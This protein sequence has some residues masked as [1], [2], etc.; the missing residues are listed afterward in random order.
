MRTLL[1]KYFHD[2][3][4]NHHRDMRDY[5]HSG[6]ELLN[7]IDLDEHILDVGCGNNLFRSHY[8]NLIGIDIANEHADHVVSIELYK[9]DHRFDVALCL[10]SLNFGS[11]SAVQYQIQKVVSLLKPK[12]RI[13]WRCNPGKHDHGNPEFDQI[14]VYPWTFEDHKRFSKQFGFELKECKWDGDTNRI[15]AEWIR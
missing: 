8:D 14:E 13:Y 11:R 9:P 4:P 1:E 3:W 15:Y 2:T 12:A 7:Q 6:W 10:G 5:T